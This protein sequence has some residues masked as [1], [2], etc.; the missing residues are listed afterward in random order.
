MGVPVQE[1][2]ARN[3]RRSV[4]IAAVVGT[5]LV[6]INHGDHLARDL[7]TDPMCPHFYAKCGLSYLVPFLVSMVSGALA[8]R[9]R[10]G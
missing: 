10:D 6:L 3:L 9:G 4:L 8:T 1:V 5:I 7:A 2:I